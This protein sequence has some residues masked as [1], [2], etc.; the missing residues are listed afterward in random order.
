MVNSQCR[1]DF[2]FQ[3]RLWDEDKFLPVAAAWDVSEDALGTLRLFAITLG[4][5][6]SVSLD[7]HKVPIP[8]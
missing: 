6:I 4:T 3:R 7:A 8:I 5:V 1:L 2:T